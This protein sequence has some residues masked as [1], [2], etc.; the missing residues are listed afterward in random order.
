MTDWRN[1]SKIM[2]SSF[3]FSNKISFQIKPPGNSSFFL[4]QDTATNISGP[5]APTSLTKEI[6]SG[7]PPVALSPSPTGMLGNQTTSG[8]KMARKKIVWNCGI[9]TEK[10]SNGMTHRAV[11]RHILCVKYNRTTKKDDKLMIIK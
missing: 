9:G 1:T 7:W 2:V 11:L 5:P 10:A 8:T 4:F 3:F 6:S